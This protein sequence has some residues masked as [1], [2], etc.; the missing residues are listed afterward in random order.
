MSS[1]VATWQA[2]LG[3]KKGNGVISSIHHHHYWYSFSINGVWVGSPEKERFQRSDK[4]G[5]SFTQSNVIVHVLNFIPRAEILISLKESTAKFYRLWDNQSPNSS[6]R[7]LHSKKVFGFARIS[8]ADPGGAGG[9]PAP[10]GYAT[11]PSRGREAPENWLRII[12]YLM[13]SVKWRKSQHLGYRPLCISI[14]WNVDR[15]VLK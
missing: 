11:E 1:Q 2:K 12:H 9:R 6:I 5:T 7:I 4:F 8:W 14:I 3:W 10:N 15:Y 13:G